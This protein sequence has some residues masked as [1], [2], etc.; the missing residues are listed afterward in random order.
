MQKKT[1]RAS[2]KGS[3]LVA[4]DEW[5]YSTIQHDQ[6][7]LFSFLP[8]T[9]ELSCLDQPPMQSIHS[10]QQK[11]GFHGLSEMAPID[12]HYE[13][14]FPSTQMPVSDCKRSQMFYNLEELNLSLSSAL[15]ENT[16]LINYATLI[17]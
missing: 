4:G 1:L 14:L 8:L 11:Q 13:N 2:D 9:C 17:F 15:T 5:Q 10:K 6:A 12:K 7:F 3:K 16:K